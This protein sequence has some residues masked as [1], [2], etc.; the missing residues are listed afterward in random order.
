MDFLRK[1][2]RRIETMATAMEAKL[3]SKPG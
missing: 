3:D 2:A 1:Q